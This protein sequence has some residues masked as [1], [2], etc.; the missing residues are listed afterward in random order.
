VIS[1]KTKARVRLTAVIAAVS[2]LV[3]VATSWAVQ[4]SLR[5][6]KAA[7]SVKAKQLARQTHA[8]SSRVIR[9]SR[10]TPE[11]YVCQIENGFRSGARKC[12]ANVVVKFSAGRVRTSY[13]NYVCF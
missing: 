2:L 5:A 9:C 6:A 13:S 7:A 3:P 11:R 4:P 8:S 12:T 1:L 10:S